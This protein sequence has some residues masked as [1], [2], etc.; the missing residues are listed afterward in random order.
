MQTTTPKKMTLTLD[1]LKVQSLYM[2][3]QA[4]IRAVTTSQTCPMKCDTYEVCS[5]EMCNDSR[6]FNCQTYE[7]GC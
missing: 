1:A 4:P 5:N 7:W 6:E 3:A 2:P